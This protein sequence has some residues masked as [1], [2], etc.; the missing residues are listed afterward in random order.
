MNKNSDFDISEI[1]TVLLEDAETIM[2]AFSNGVP[3]AKVIRSVFGPIL[4]RWINE[5]DF[6]IVQKYANPKIISFK[7]HNSRSCETNLKRKI[8]PIW[9]GNL[10]FGDIGISMTM[11]G[12]DEAR[13]RAVPSKG[14]KDVSTKAAIYF[15]QPVCHIDG[16]TY[17]RRDVVKLHAN[18]LGG[19]HLQLYKRDKQ[20]LRETIGFEVKDSTNIQTML[21]KEILKAK[22]DPKR[23]PTVYDAADLVM[24]DT[25]YTFA[26]SIIDHRK[27]IESLK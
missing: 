16:K 5:G 19:A 22:S 2:D 13:A 26:K 12:S 7:Y 27:T 23:R 1:V 25:A 15:G 4:R 8:Y 20:R 18:E 9:F 24:Q 11:G 6:H 14:M 17:K 21:G 3:E 10:R